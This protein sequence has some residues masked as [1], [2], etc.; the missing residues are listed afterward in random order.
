MCAGSA[1]SFSY[2]LP[3]HIVHMDA[4]GCTV[5]LFCWSEQ[6]W[7]ESPNLSTLQKHFAKQKHGFVWYRNNWNIFEIALICSDGLPPPRWKWRR[8]EWAKAICTFLAN[9]IGFQK[10]LKQLLCLSALEQSNGGKSRRVAFEVQPYVL[11]SHDFLTSKVRQD[12]SDCTWFRG[13]CLWV[14]PWWF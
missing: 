13:H 7:L 1:E 5:L 11:R 9:Q 2:W 14:S 10:L 3:V 6:R 4:H 12:F 8:S